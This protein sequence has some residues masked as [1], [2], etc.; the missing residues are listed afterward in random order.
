MRLW[1]K[2]C[3]AQPNRPSKHIL[4]GN[5][6][7][8]HFL[9]DTGIWILSSKDSLTLVSLVSLGVELKCLGKFLPSTPRVDFVQFYWAGPKHDNLIRRSRPFMLMLTLKCQFQISSGAKSKFGYQSHVSFLTYCA[10]VA[11]WKKQAACLV[12]NTDSSHIL[13]GSPEHVREMQGV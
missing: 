13:V 4:H 5:S 7:L 2:L 6:S 3:P 8:T 12:S 1:K 11:K 9:V 10:K